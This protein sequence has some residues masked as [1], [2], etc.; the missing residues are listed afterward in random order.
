YD[1]MVM[2]DTV[3]RPGLDAGVVRVHGTSKALAFTSDVT[4]RYCKANPFEGGKQAVAEAYRNLCATGAKPL[5]TTDNLNFG[6]PEKPEIMGQ[7]VG[8]I[9][10]IGNAVSELDMPIVS[11]NVSLYN[12]TDGTS[13]LPTPTI[14]AVGLMT[15]LDQLIGTAPNDED[16]IILLGATTGHLGQS[17]LL[18]ELFNREDG[19]APHVDLKAEWAAGELVRALQS[20]GYITA[21]HDLSDGG[22]ALAAAE[23]VLS[24][25]LGIV[26][27]D[28][29]TGWFFGEDQARY[30][31]A[32]SN[33]NAVLSAAKHAKVPAEIIG[34]A[35]G[36]V[37]SL[38]KTS[39]TLNDLRNAFTNGLPKAIC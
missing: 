9:K 18:K 33:P 25:N 21:A 11:G 1:T 7:F 23:M 12:E 19:D 34:V 20:D 13:I 22:L 36:D 27:K 28:G 29:D 26:L 2:A 17:A 14:G 6:N 5:A 8:C 30:L 32:T 24:G 16:N 15:G 35:T 39:V 37:L 4:P 38:G 31:I 3:K 10:G